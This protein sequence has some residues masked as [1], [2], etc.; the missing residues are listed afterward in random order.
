M[1]LLGSRAEIC[2]VHRNMVWMDVTSP[3][4]SCEASACRGSLLSFLGD[5]PRASRAE[6]SKSRKD[7][8]QIRL[9]SV[10]WGCGLPGM[11][12]GP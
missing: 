2:R 8:S 1:R 6:A 4:K 9:D 7:S 3:S 11:V 10:P 5:A 12:F